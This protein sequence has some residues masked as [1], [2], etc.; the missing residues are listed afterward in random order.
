VFGARRL[1]LLGPC[2][3][4]VRHDDAPEDEGQLVVP[5]PIE[6]DGEHALFA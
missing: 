1:G 4:M 2:R 6:A 3:S 5:E